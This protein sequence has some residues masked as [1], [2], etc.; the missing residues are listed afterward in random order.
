MRVVHSTG[1]RSRAG[2]SHEDND[3]TVITLK[4]A[5]GLTYKQAHSMLRWQGR[6]PRGGF[7][8]STFLINLRDYDM[9]IKGKTVL[10]FRNYYGA[11]YKMQTFLKTHPKGTW[12]VYVREHVLCVK[13]GVIFDAAAGESVKKNYT[14]FYYYKIGEK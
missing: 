4:H 1:G 7:D 13:D 9:T 10:A 8:L 3:C 12:I 6:K 2:F 14:V 5:F 11:G